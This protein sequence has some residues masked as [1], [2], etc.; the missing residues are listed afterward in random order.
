METC[1]ITEKMLQLV[2]LSSRGF[3]G[4]PGLVD[5]AGDW[6]GR[7]GGHSTAD[8]EAT[9]LIQGLRTR[10]QNGFISGMFHGPC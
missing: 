4:S 7:G 3:E 2:N 9:M 1:Y 6:R 5:R 10:G 8:D